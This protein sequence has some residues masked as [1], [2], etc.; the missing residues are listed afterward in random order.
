MSILKWQENDLAMTQE[1]IAPECFPVDREEHIL[2]YV[3]VVGLGLSTKG[4]D[5][6]KN[7]RASIIVLIDQTEKHNQRCR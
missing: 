1:V 2:E 3:L 4:E 7:Y 5:L 6:K